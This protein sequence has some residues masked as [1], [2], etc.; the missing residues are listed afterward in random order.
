MH[1][2]FRSQIF[3]V[4]PEF[5]D[6]GVTL[7]F[8]FVPSGAVWWEGVGSPPSSIDSNELNQLDEEGEYANYEVVERWSPERETDD[9][10]EPK[11]DFNQEDEVGWGDE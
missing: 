7:R 9:T 1:K 11:W 6:E 3:D 4:W 10:D 8:E 2:N 5:N